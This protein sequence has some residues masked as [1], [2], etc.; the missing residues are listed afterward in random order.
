MAT[1]N[2]V[3][4]VKRY[5]RPGVLTKTLLEQYW[6]NNGTYFDP[7]NVSAVYILPDTYTGSATG[8]SPA[9]YINRDLSAAGTSAYGLLHPSA[10]EFVVA[11]FDVSNDGQVQPPSSYLPS[12]GVGLSSIYSAGQGHYAVVLQGNGLDFPAFSAVGSYFD[13]WLVD[14]FDAAESDAAHFKLYWNKFSVYSDRIISYTEPFQVTTKAKLAQKYIKL[15]SK[16]NL[17]INV[18]VYMANKDLSDDLKEIWREAVIDPN[19]VQ[20]RIRRRNLHTTGMMSDVIGWTN[21]GVEV[22]SENTIMYLFDTSKP[23]MEKGDFVVDA[24]YELLGQTF[25]TDDFSVVVD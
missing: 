13:I 2:G 23:Y 18:D 6:A 20:I 22:S 16:V 19:T 5:N 12:A 24:Q 1:F 4:V 25:F 3:N 21:T 8:G 14:D 11:Y 7:A 9:L 10:L 17:M 15:N